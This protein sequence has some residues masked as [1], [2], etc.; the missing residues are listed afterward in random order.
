LRNA[1]NLDDPVATALL[2]AD[3]LNG[4][5]ERYAL[6]G[7]LLLAAYGEPRETHD[8]D[9]AVVDLTADA[10]RRALESAGIQ[11]A[12]SFEHMRFGGLNI[13]RIVLLGGD[14]HTGLNALDLIHPRSPR[15]CAAAMD[16][17]VIA[18]LRDRQIHALTADDFVIFKALATR[19]RDLDDAASVLERSQ[20][21]LDVAFIDAEVAAL[22]DEIADWDVRERW[23][24][25]RARASQR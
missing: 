4:A 1:V 24:S 11:S 25:I 7:G 20:E 14:E 16:R 12:V 2:V 3:A 19:D 21:L 10:A 22:S 9:V 15:Y 5:G 17:A 8:V 13:S 6:Y 18:P 23:A